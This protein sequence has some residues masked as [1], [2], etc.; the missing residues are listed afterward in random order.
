MSTYKSTR[1]Q[2]NSSQDE[3]GTQSNLSQDERNT[4]NN[5]KNIRNAADVAI[6]SKNPYAMAIGGAVKAADKI[7]GG[8][9]TEALG[10]AMTKANKTVPGGK[11]IQDASNKLS[12]SGASDAIGKAAS[13]KNGTGGGAASTGA[14]AGSQAGNAASS[15]SGGGG[16]TGGTDALSSPSDMGGFNPFS[17]KNTSNNEKDDSQNNGDDKSEASFE[18]TGT[19]KMP[20]KAAVMFLAPIFVIFLIFVG[21]LNAITNNFADYEDALGASGATGGETGGI[22]YSAANPEAREFYERINN[23][24]LSMQANGKSVD[25]LKIVAV[26]HILTTNDP[27]IDY[28]SMTEAK[29][30]EIADAMFSGN[31]YNETVFKENLINNIFPKYLPGTS[32]KKREQMA[33][34]VF[35]YIDR[36]YSFIGLDTSSTCAAIGSCTYEI[37]GFYIPGSGNITK[38]MSIK[39][40]KVRLMECGSPYGNGS[41]TTPIDQDLVSFEDYVAG[42]AYAEIGDYAPDEAIKAQMIASRSFALARPTGMNNGL[43]KKLEEENGQWILQISSCVADQVFCN[44]NE[45]CSYMGGGD[46]QGGVVRSG[47]VQGAERT[48]DPLPEDH[49]LRSLAASVQGE[50]LVNNQGNIIQAGYLSDV[51]NAF[52]SLANQ[53]MNYRQILLQVYGGEVRNY[54]ATD[55]QK[56]SCN[57]GSSGCSNASTGPYASWKQYEGSWTEIN[58]GDSG[59]TIRQIGCLVTSISMLIAKSGVE[60]NISNFNPGTFVEFL[61]NNG[62]FASGGNF[63]WSSATL[64]APSFKYQGQISVSGYT[65]E[66]K[67]SKIKELLDQ[68]A[69]VTAEVKGNTGQ[70]WVAID[71]ISGNNVIM[72]D[73]GS[74]STDL[75]G[76]YDWRNTS[77]LAY[78]KVN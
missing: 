32:E 26:Y 21:L 56:M 49:K 19:G 14:S 25:A 18:G 8:K 43:G 33:E 46:G 63:V 2:D 28:E 1:S 16:A 68:G 67:L 65:R 39:D 57:T 55:I 47:K 50:V 30:R 51:S 58:L 36:Y 70:H 73:P 52:T 24:K 64:A 13:M 7:T 75:W 20:V 17:K 40:L 54:G 9:S 11:K 61:N 69:Y 66:Q 38:S 59:Q 48:R 62:G 15:A 4:K 72:M 3:R 76:Q 23:V 22:L 10:K 44:I 27:N 60:T 74:Q 12:E 42:V 71:A 77:R 37:K 41:Y 5:T 29:I 31:S 6:A 53:G 45:G 35:D 34:D 78:Y